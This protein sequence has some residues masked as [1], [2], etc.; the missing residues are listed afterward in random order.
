MSQA[1]PRI[2]AHPCVET[3]RSGRTEEADRPATLTTGFSSSR[4]PIVSRV[5]LQGM[6]G[7]LKG[8]L[9]LGNRGIVLLQVEV[10]PASRLVRLVLRGTARHFFRQLPRSR[11]IILSPR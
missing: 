6:Q 10:R 2:H 1:S 9:K 8:A 5:F 7:P 4:Q 3:V 11:Q